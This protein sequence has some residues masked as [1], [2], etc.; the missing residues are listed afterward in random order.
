MRRS[1][2]SSSRP[3]RGGGAQQA[4]LTLRE[5]VKVLHKH[6]GPPAPLPTADPFELILCENVAY[7]APR[8]RSIKARPG[9]E[10][11]RAN[12]CREP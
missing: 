3:V 1:E 8:A 2:G 9:R 5:A 12:L 7:L 10:I 11:L 6:H 4:S